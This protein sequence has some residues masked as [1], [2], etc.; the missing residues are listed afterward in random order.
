M[1][2][3]IRHPPQAAV[4]TG[5]HRFLATV[6]SQT[7][8]SHLPLQQHKLSININQIPNMKQISQLQPVMFWFVQENYFSGIPIRLVAGADIWLYKRCSFAGKWCKHDQMPNIYLCINV[9][10][11]SRE[12]NVQNGWTCGLRSIRTTHL[13]HCYKENCALLQETGV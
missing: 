12:E 7:Q 8:T 6:Q 4:S 11:C 9:L 13:E 10:F 5:S 3:F 1:W 2:P